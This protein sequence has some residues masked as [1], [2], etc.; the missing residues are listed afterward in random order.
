MSKIIKIN[1]KGTKIVVDGY[2]YTLQHTLSKTKRWK[3]S[4]KTKYNCPGTLSS[5][6]ILTN[7]VLQI[8]HNHAGNKQVKI[9]E[10]FKNDIKLRS[11]KTCDKPSQIFAEAVSQIPAEALLFLP[12]ESVAK[13]TIRNQRTNNNPALN[14]INDIVI[15]G[16]YNLLL[17]YR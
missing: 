14:C 15:E 12:K 8:E 7:P 13:R 4:N 17:K 3:C 9:I 6:L 5:S 2:A 16:K 10:K 11:R 1:E